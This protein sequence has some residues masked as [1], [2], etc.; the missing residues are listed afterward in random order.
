MHVEIT[1]GTLVDQLFARAITS[2]VVFYLLNESKGGVGD[3]QCVSTSKL[4]AIICVTCH[5]DL[6][7]E[8]IWY[9]QDNSNLHNNRT[10]ALGRVLLHRYHNNIHQS[11]LQQYN[12][13]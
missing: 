3:G 7:Q 13:E 10:N 8:Y 1:L 5:L 2:S 6:P 9:V 11:H 12:K 4:V